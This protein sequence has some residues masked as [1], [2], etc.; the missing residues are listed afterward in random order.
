[1]KKKLMADIKKGLS[2]DTLRIAL[3]YS[4]QHR[5]VICKALK[6]QYPEI[7]PDD[8][9]NEDE[10]YR[11]FF[12]LLISP[13]TRESLQEVL[14]EITKKKNKKWESV[15][16]LDHRLISR[17][18]DEV[19]NQFE[20]EEGRI[21]DLLDSVADQGV[22]EIRDWF[23][24]L[25]TS[26]MTNKVH[27]ESVPT[28]IP[29][30][31][32][33]VLQQ[34]W[35]Q[36][37]EQIEIYL[38]EA[39]E[40]DPSNDRVIWFEEQVENIGYI[41]K[42]YESVTDLDEVKEECAA[43]INSIVTSDNKDLQVAIAK[44]QQLIAVYEGSRRELNN[45]L[46]KFRQLSL[47]L[48]KYS[49]EEHHHNLALK[50]A[51]N[52][53]D[54]EQVSRISLLAQEVNGQY[55]SSV[56]DIIHLVEELAELVTAESKEEYSKSV[57][58]VKVAKQN[59]TEDNCK[60]I[61][62][63]QISS[64]TLSI[65]EKE[66]D[67]DINSPKDCDE[68][69][70]V[71]QAYTD[72]NTESL[73][74][75]ENNCRTIDIKGDGHLSQDEPKSSSRVI[76][77]LRGDQKPVRN[78]PKPHA[79]NLNIDNKIID[80][81]S[82]RFVSSIK[83]EILPDEQYS[84]HSW[85]PNIDVDE[86][87]QKVLNSEG[88]ERLANAQGLA[89]ALVRDDRID[90][91]YHIAVNLVQQGCPRLNSVPSEPLRAI[92]LGRYLGHG[93]GEEVVELADT[94]RLLYKVQLTDRHLRGHRAQTLLCFAAL[95]YPALM[96]PYATDAEE[97]L[98][99]L[100]LDEHLS[101][102]H[103]L[104]EHI[105]DQE[106]HF[107]VLTH[108][109][110]TSRLEGLRERVQAW[111]DSNRTHRFKY[112]PAT[113]VWKYLL[114]SGQ[115][116][117][118]AVS[119]LL[120]GGVGDLEE[121]KQL[122]ASLKDRSD[123][124]QIIDQA[125][126]AVRDRKANKKP[127]EAGPRT[128][129]V[130]RCGELAVL[131]S[132]WVSAFDEQISSV[133][134]PGS[135]QVLRDTRRRLL[136][137]LQKAI[138]QLDEL[139]N[140]STLDEF[141]A[142]SCASRI[143]NNVIER[144]EGRKPDTVPAHSVWW[145]SLNSILL[146]SETYE[147]R[148]EKWEVNPLQPTEKLLGSLVNLVSPPPWEEVMKAAQ[149]RCDHVRTGQLLDWLRFEKQ[150]DER[151]LDDWEERRERSLKSCK[152]K[153]S[154]KLDQVQ[155]DIERA[156]ALGYLSEQKRAE[157]VAKLERFEKKE[158]V[159]L[160]HAY[161]EIEKVDRELY[162]LRMRH[163]DEIRH[164]LEK[165]EALKDK[166][167][168]ESQI[169]ELLNSG[170]I[171]TADEYL[172]KLE[173]G[174][175]I[176]ESSG[177]QDT[178]NAFFPGFVGEIQSYLGNKAL[179]A[180]FLGKLEKGKVIGPL[181]M[182]LVRPTQ[183]RNAVAMLKAWMSVKAR[184]GNIVDGLR[185][186]LLGLGFGDVS[187]TPD[188][189][190]EREQVIDMR[191]RPVA[192]RDICMVPRYGSHAKGQYRLICMWDRPAEEDVLTSAQ[193]HSHGQPTLILYMGRLSVKS[194]RNLAVRCR[195]R[196]QTVLV[197]D[198]TLVYFLCTERKSRLASLF[199]CT[200]PFTIAQPY[201]TTSSHVPPEMFV[202]R[203]RELEAIFDHF[204]TNLIYGGRQLGKT[205]L[206]REVVR[207]F[208][209]PEEGIIVAWL[210]LKERLIGLSKPAD[211][212]WQLID[213]DLCDKKV[214]T[215]KVKRS[216]DAT[217]EAIRHWLDAEPQRRIVMLLDEADAF[218]AQDASDD[219]E[220]F[221]TVGR[222]KGLM[223]RT[224][225]RFKV[226]FAGLHNVQRTSRDINTPL[227]HFGKPLCI[228]P[229]LSNGEA[230]EAYQLVERPL[231]QLGYRFES[232]SLINRILAQT[233]YYP[234]LIQIFC[235]HLL[236]YLQEDAWR[237]F[238]PKT[239][240]PYEIERKHVEAVSQNRELQQRIRSRFQITLD[241]DNRY[242]VVAL[243]M[244]LEAKKSEV[245]VEDDVDGMIMND[246][247]REALSWWPQGFPDKSHDAFRA[248]LDEMVDLGVLRRAGSDFKAY[249]LRSLAIANLLGSRNEIEEALLEASD[250]EP[251]KLYEA[252][253]YRRGRKGDPWVRSP[254]TG[255]QESEI[256]TEE[257]AVLTLFGTYLSGLDQ[258]Y[259]FLNEMI[260]GNDFVSLDV[261]EGLQDYKQFE[262]RLQQI[263]DKAKKNTGA[264]LQLL[265]IPHTE[266][267]TADWVSLAVERL[268]RRRS[269]QTM[270][271][272]LFIG[273]ARDAWEWIE[274]GSINDDMKTKVETLSL[275]PWAGSFVTVWAKDA[276]FGPLSK[277]D[278]LQWEQATG[279]WGGILALLG[280]ELKNDPTKWKKVFESFKGAIPEISR[281]KLKDDIPENLVHSFVTLASYK[282]PISC[283][284][285]LQLID[286]STIPNE[287]AVFIQKIIYWADLL[288]LLSPG[289]GGYWKI[290]PTVGVALSQ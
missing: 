183:R 104:R 253:T 139:K 272:V 173:S 105:L 59:E 219:D 232:P 120:H 176:P 181:D 143:V 273:G 126:K 180:E 135:E 266:P 90:L 137:R 52:N 218:L 279:W 3:G 42:K 257:N 24:W 33:E 170:D 38:Q 247:R 191:V 205:A 145:R 81:N 73:N 55:L 146:A 148:G 122:L 194:W 242:Q 198:E 43:T 17:A 9:L 182:H 284:E 141:A 167:E 265:V 278:L 140:T 235:G 70:R 28:D 62:S 155:N 35:R 160:Q 241:L 40:E 243:S 65:S 36:T 67:S 175:S 144:L 270:V 115:T 199:N 289:E 1:M 261:T 87:V 12:N 274:N 230:R 129:M 4:Q 103:L 212:V 215:R 290:D 95:L 165:I 255:Q 86:L 159:N 121:A 7:W 25:I 214:I 29:E 64:S 172:L 209:R 136:G 156:A 117:G 125:D 188:R 163:V 10:F 22:P 202:G 236:E 223:E 249:A 201:I 11:K 108:I 82:P 74:N 79:I 50:E 41:A 281:S 246:I 184:R 204:G 276:G 127:I 228:G 116:L 128:D 84:M 264:G 168:V 244:A 109:D 69:K 107:S 2:A 193:T 51:A 256:L 34:Q 158:I 124:A 110:S 60:D 14:H 100:P 275:T 88:E 98:R 48:M 206:L 269:R 287:G 102:L 252:E 26:N 32:P 97:L 54:Y 271:R 46:T 211:M 76:G 231:Y 225:R 222:L 39:I 210:D 195:E 239:S 178:L 251:P 263:L 91:A 21:D 197:I 6:K 189:K 37:L 66:E 5:N 75:R 268:N 233:N 19:G 68:T 13:D 20:L 164:R 192:D 229:L 114:K 250:K 203:N 31:S 169:D 89:W 58:G 142:V 177:F 118:R 44:A 27:P 254:L 220:K 213:E 277:E 72:E 78:A 134:S 53:K 162:K 283:E 111:Y 85:S 63:D 93:T 49:E 234:N 226:V 83:R 92:Y 186:F 96:T 119:I 227:A 138:A 131:L 248:L 80:L 45:W 30:P 282:D 15:L 179:S 132:E 259:E 166:P 187:V 94:L 262:N 286:D 280:N 174:E 245:K 238:D 147:L 133:G 61:T 157:M 71:Q 151:R 112:E 267:W 237:L 285:W 23:E 101:S 153:F 260:E 47:N 161:N 288:G 56:A 207:R 224:N 106:V 57:S 16:R 216:T 196:G 123:A 130:R 150:I 200:L 18:L 240:P 77:N 152:R 190:G 149:K 258:V 221:H 154:E 185:E 217:I 8:R 113:W 208:H 99:R 171:L